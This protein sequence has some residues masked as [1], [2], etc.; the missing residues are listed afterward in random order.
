MAEKKSVPSNSGPITQ[1]VPL[2]SGL[3]RQVIIP[4][5]CG[6]TCDL[7]S[8]ASGEDFGRKNYS[9]ERPLIRWSPL[10]N[11]ERGRIHLLGILGHGL[12]RQILGGGKF[13]REA[14]FPTAPLCQLSVQ[15]SR[16]SPRSRRD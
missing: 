13:W 2:Y 7:Q 6:A 5:L 16:E 15:R 9:W 10:M 3:I 1:V 12:E 11:H 4:H 14:N 8:E